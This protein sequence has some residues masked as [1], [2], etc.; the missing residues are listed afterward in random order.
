MIL[1]GENGEE[2]ARGKINPD[3]D[4]LYQALKFAL[5]CVEEI[6]RK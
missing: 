5:A 2:K 6:A 4:M 3:A 1:L